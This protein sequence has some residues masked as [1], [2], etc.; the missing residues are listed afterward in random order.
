MSGI[1]SSRVTVKAAILKKTGKDG[2]G[3]ARLPRAGLGRQA[4]GKLKFPLHWKVALKLHAF[5]LFARHSLN[6]RKLKAISYTHGLRATV[7]GWEV[8]KDS[9]VWRA[10][11]DIKFIFCNSH[12]TR[13]PFSTMGTGHSRSFSESTTHQGFVSAH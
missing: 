1:L 7:A 12:W 9:S 2:M 6:S 4:C 3:L 13:D 8:T 11:S 5:L 10:D